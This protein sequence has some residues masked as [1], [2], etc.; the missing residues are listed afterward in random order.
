[1]TREPRPEPQPAPQ[2]PTAPVKF[3]AWPRKGTLAQ[4]L[5]YLIRFNIV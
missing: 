3:Y 4:R 1:M 2:E 5:A